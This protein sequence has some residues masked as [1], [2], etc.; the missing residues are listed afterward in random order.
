MFSFNKLHY[1]ITFES[2]FMLFDLLRMFC[3]LLSETLAFAAG[4]LYE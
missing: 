3:A 1:K 4:D 2:L